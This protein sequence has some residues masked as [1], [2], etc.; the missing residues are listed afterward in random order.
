MDPSHLL[1]RQRKRRTQNVYARAL[2]LDERKE[3]VGGIRGFPKEW[4]SKEAQ[5]KLGKA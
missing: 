1:A 2:A 3:V 4:L 5:A